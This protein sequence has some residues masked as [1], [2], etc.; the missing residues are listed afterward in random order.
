MT[1]V[2]V[3]TVCT[4]CRRGQAKLDRNSMRCKDW[5]DKK[6]EIGLIVVKRE[7]DAV[8]KCLLQRADDENTRHY[9]KPL[10]N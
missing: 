6:I 9:L 7:T 1:A 2:I 5:G 8:S 10:R 3:K 4:E